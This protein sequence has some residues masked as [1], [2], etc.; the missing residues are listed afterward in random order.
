M[1][2][3]IILSNFAN[4]NKTKLKFVKSKNKNKLRY[5]EIVIFILILLV[6]NFLLPRNAFKNTWIILPNDVNPYFTNELI[7]KDLSVKLSYPKEI[8]GKLIG[9]SQDG[10]IR[11]NINKI[12][13]YLPVQLL[14]QKTKNG[15]KNKNLPIGDESVDIDIP[16]SKDYKPDDLIKINQNWNYHSNDRPNYLRNDA[17][18]AVNKMFSEAQKAGYSLKILNAY[19]SFDTQ[20]LMYL[21]AMAKNGINQKIV[22]KPGHSEHQ[23]GT[24]ID[25]GSFVP[26]SNSEEG[27][28]STKE[29]KW[30]I[31][32][33]NKFGFYQS[34]T[35]NN[36]EESGYISEPWHYRYLGV[37]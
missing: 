11:F 27:F 6:I 14:L 21:N 16:L 26:E 29:G 18:K 1:D 15:A 5:V 25:V 13:Y 2:W 19:R 30:M 9:N 12:E 23:L 35:K 3:R 28:A 7:K 32:N 4:L 24:T 36:I 34:Y 33:A 10:S 37:K 22:A 20:R 17:A 31:E 8:E